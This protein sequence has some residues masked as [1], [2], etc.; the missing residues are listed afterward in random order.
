M[1]LRGGFS[2]LRSGVAFG[3]ALVFL[4]G[5]YVI[6]RFLAWLF[7]AKA[8]ERI[9]VEKRTAFQLSFAV[10]G[11]ILFFVGVYSGFFPDG[12]EKKA[13]LGAFVL[14]FAGYVAVMAEYLA[15]RAEYF[16]LFYF[17]SL[18]G[19]NLSGTC[20]LEYAQTHIGRIKNDF[21]APKEAF[22]VKK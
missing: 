2:W 15:R 9:L 14:Y 3:F 22:L 11:L 16:F 6:D 8:L 5:R 19:R 21:G 7:G 4:G 20:G 1:Y 13:L 17:L 12:F 10:Y 18:R